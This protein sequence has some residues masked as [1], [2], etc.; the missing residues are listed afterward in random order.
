M[1][2]NWTD[3]PYTDREKLVGTIYDAGVIRRSDLMFLLG[4]KR[5]KFDN[6]L[7]QLR[8][9]VMLVTSRDHHGNTV[10]MLDE[11]GVR[12]AHQLCHIEGKIVTMGAQIS[13]QIG[14]N[15]IL[16]RLVNANGREGVRWW[17]TREASDQLWD[18]RKKMGTNDADIR[19]THIRPDAL[20]RTPGSEFFWIEYDNATESSRQIRKK[21]ALYVTNLRELKD[22]RAQ[23]V[24]WITPTAARTRWL[25]SKWDELR[26]KSNIEM[27]FYTAGEETTATV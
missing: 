6:Q 15:D 13:H 9:Q 11:S 23:R 7:L 4:W 8:K 14:V 27:Q 2:L 25:Q 5:S 10:Y 26:V 20:L 18:A 19:K 17:S 22:R 24:M 21:F 12:A 1:I 16:M 3:G